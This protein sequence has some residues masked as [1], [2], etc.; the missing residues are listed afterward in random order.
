VVLT[1]AA[2]GIV[3]VRE[4]F[5]DSRSHALPLAQND[6]PLSLFNTGRNM[7]KCSWQI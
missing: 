4:G 2:A 3:Q 7:P 1:S 5:F 6:R